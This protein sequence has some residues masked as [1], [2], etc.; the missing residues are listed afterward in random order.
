MKIVDEEMFAHLK[1]FYNVACQIYYICI[2]LH[3]LSRVFVDEMNLHIS[4]SFH[5]IL[6]L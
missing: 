4:V 2:L 5:N 1:A 6:D 3:I